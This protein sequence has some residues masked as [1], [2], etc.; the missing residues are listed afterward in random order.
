MDGFASALMLL[1]WICCDLARTREHD[2]GTA[3]EWM[4]AAALFTAA[5]LLIWLPLH[6]TEAALQ[7]WLAHIAIGSVL[8]IVRH[9]SRTVERMPHPVATLGTLALV[10]V[11]LGWQL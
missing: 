1:A 9:R 3:L 7:V 5:A 8:L 10:G 6:G 2:D 11:M 4:L